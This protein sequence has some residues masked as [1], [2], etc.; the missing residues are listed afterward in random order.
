M[1]LADDLQTAIDNIGTRLA[2]ITG[3]DHP[4]I[5]LDGVTYNTNEYRSSLIR[6]LKEL[7]LQQRMAGGPWV[8]TTRSIV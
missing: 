5:S 1:A 3:Y 7:L 8:Q 4:T 6:D 2:A